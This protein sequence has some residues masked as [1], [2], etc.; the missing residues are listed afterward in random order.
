[1]TRLSRLPVVCALAV[2]SLMAVTAVTAAT[3]KYRDAQGRVV[4]SDM[5]PPA[6]VQE[7]DILERP[8]QVVRRTAA[9]A[10][11]STASAPAAPTLQGGGATTQQTDPE[12]E[13]RRKKMTEEEQAKQKQQQEKDAL[14]RAD[15]CSRARSH[16]AALNDGLRMSRT[17]AQGE[18]EVLDDKARAEEMQRARQVIASDCK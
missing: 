14:Q 17:N 1:M 18:R 15:N 7:K 16:L 11:A 4:V 6:S 5:P 3:W 10:P 8:N 2:V 12:L 13:A 9:A